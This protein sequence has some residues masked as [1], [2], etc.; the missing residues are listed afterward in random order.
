METRDKGQVSFYYNRE[1]RLEKADADARFA[2]E[3]HKS[4]KRGF[5]KSLTATRSLR[6]LFFALILMFIAASISS[7]LVGSRN[8]GELA[9]SQI[10]AEAMWFEG[11]VYV[12]VTRSLPWY[13]KLNKLYSKKDTSLLNVLEISAG[14]GNNISDAVMQAG[15]KEIKFR[16][17][18]E[19]KP[20]MAIVVVRFYKSA[21]EVSRLELFVKVS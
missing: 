20:K 18:A 10:T 3:Q 13:A 9:S 7:Y 8:T 21:D 17:V 15:E 19:T 6:H 11:H 16:F 14:D 5:I 4:I 2:L 1:R 12:T